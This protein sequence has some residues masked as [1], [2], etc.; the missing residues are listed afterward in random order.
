VTSSVTHAAATAPAY[1]ERLGPGRFHSTGNAQGAWGHDQQHMAPISGLLTRAIEECAPRDD[2]IISRIAFDILGVITMGPVDIE[3]RVIRPGRTIELVEAELSIAG[4]V[5]VRATA[6]RLATSDTSTIAGSD[7]PSMPG[8]DQGKPWQGSGIWDGG[9]IRTLEF[10][11][12]P[13]WQPGHGRVW[14]TS[15]TELVAG[16]ESSPL[17]RYLRLV[18]TA[19]GIAV[20]ADPATLLFP[21]TDLTV[22]LVR[23][24][25][26]DW[27]GLDTTVSY[28]ADGV[29]L[30][31]SVLYDL[32]GPVGRAAQ[33]L[34][35]RPVGD[36]QAVR[37]P[38]AT[39]FAT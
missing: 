11:V 24:P 22:H 12:L 28:G 36:I 23:Q 5:A 10:R 17:S 29:G 25:V 33:T 37:Q 7:V 35:L 20:R 19:N 2:L 1:F 18:D 14:L 31:A 30:T 13:G 27:V 39:P 38:E 9:F 21:N 34:T 4:R 26:G 6:W 15:G 8:P 16:E 3:A 32:E